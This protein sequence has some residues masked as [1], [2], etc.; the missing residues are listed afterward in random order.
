M[1]TISI[2]L[3]EKTLK[4]SSKL[5]E[6]ENLERSDAIRQSI[7]CGLDILSRKKAADKYSEGAFSLSE[8][9]NF[10]NISIPEMM[11]VLAN[12][13]IKA[14]YSM[15]DADDSLKNIGKLIKR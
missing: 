7:A 2:R 3:D 4:R 9:A 5:A 11:D 6:T 1:K 15:K 14:N 12:R 10:A 13:G 8:A